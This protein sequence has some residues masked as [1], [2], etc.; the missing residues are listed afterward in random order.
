MRIAVMAA[1]GVG[2][3]FGARL[4]ADGHDVFF[5]ARG[6]HLDAIKKNGLKIDS[7]NGNLQLPRPN[8]TNDP[9]TVGLVDIVLFAV[10]LWDTEKAAELSKP[11]VGPTTR[12]ITV[13]NGV[14]AVERMRP[15]LGRDQVVG[16][17][18][19][20]ATV[21][22]QPGV[23]KNISQFATLHFGWP[24]KRPDPMLDAFVKA[25]KAAKCDVDL[26]KDI[27]VE[28]WEKFI[29]LTAM[30]GSTASRRSSI[31]PI[32]ATDEGRNF[33]RALMEEARAVGKASGV[34]VPESYIEQRM[35]FLT[36]KVDPSMKASMAHDLERGNRLELDWLNGKVAALGDKYGI[37]TPASDEVVGKLSA[38]KMG[39]AA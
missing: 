10:K 21:I 20:I 32:I 2:G 3:Y 25:G 31:G 18:A 23:I 28:R 5:I 1:G 39:R 13:Q 22:E 37:D 11:L 24:D 6:A 8:V 27:E 34:N 38:H 30:A 16:G 9:G 19:Y 12:V 4:A 15:I 29:F 14:D 7:V 36:T 33:Y 26:S 35:A 17:V